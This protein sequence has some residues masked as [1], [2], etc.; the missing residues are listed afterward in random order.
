MIWF[1]SALL[2]L[3]AYISSINWLSIYWSN[4][5]KKHHSSVPLLG[6]FFLGLGLAG[7]RATRPFWWTS[8]F[9][10]YG[11]LVAILGLPYLLFQFWRT[12]GF[13]RLHQF[14]CQEEGRKTTVTLYKSGVGVVLVEFDPPVRPNP[15]ADYR[16]SSIS[17]SC[18]WR[19]ID[20]SYELNELGEGRIIRITKRGEQLIVED[21]PDSEP[22][23]ASYRLSGIKLV[24]TSNAS[25]HS[26]S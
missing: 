1:S 12:A 9:I 7:F 18:S 24:E 19:R 21:T 11:T 10:D 15:T 26:Q 5:D 20:S 22:D 4:R 16:T 17:R 3:G 2:L 14:R 13:N 8:I 25:A 6:A 23:S